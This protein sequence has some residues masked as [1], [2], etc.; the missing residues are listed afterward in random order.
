MTIR[1]LQSMLDAHSVALIGASARAGSIGLTVARNLLAGGFKGRIDFVNPKWGTIEGRAC[2]VSGRAD[3]R[4]VGKR[5][6]L[7]CRS[8]GRR[9]C[10]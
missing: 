4:A 6:Q 5:E 3:A 8:C 1:N 10:H 2:A 7:S 9:S